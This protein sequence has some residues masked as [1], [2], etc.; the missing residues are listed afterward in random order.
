MDDTLLEHHRRHLDE[1]GYTI[2]EDVIDTALVEAI[3]ADLR[4]LEQ[5][6]VS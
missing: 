1:H 3:A 2:L 6:I 5:E 4:R